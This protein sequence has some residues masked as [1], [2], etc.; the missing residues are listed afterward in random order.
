MIKCF[1]LRMERITTLSSERQYKLR[2]YREYTFV[3]SSEKSYFKKFVS[4]SPL[5]QL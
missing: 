4:F 3:S 1:L 2:Q 5:A